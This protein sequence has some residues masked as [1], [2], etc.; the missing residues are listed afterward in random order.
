MSDNTRVRRS[1]PLSRIASLAAPVVLCASLAACGGR[2]PVDRGSS[3]NRTPGV[4]SALDVS[5]LYRDVGLFVET[6]P[7]PFVGATHAFA[8]ASPDTTLVLLTLSLPNRA[9]T[10][11]REGDHYRAGYDVIV[12]A[13]RG[14]GSIRKEQG[15]Q[16]V[17]V[18]S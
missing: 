5:R 12:D 11:V 9:L 13:R 18:A 7:F 17:R 1:A 2:T 15:R 3:P 14:G 6:T 10:F 8:T 4:P 16:I